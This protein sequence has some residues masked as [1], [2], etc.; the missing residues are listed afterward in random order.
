MAEGG[1]NGSFVTPHIGRGRGVLGVDEPKVGK[2][3]ML[4]Y[5]SATAS[6]PPYTK[7]NEPKSSTPANVGCDNVTQQLRDLIGELGSQIGDSIVT[8]LL[9]NQASILPDPAPSSE[10]LPSMTMPLSPNLDLSKL[11]LIVK[12]DI[13][14]PQMFRGDGSDKC[15]ILEWI[16]QM[17]VFL[18]KKG[19]NKADS[20]EEI[21]NHLCG[22]AKSIVKVKLKSSS[23]AVLCPEVV[24]EVLRRYFS[25]SP[26]SCQP[27]ADFYATQPKHN[28]CPVDYWVRLNEAAELA[29]AHLKRCGGKM[30]NMSSEIVMM[31]IRNCPNSDLASVFRCKPI[32]KW[33]AEEVQEAIDEHERDFRSRRQLPSAFKAAVNQAA[34][35]KGPV[36][37]QVTVESEDVGVNSAAC[38]ASPHPKTNESVE[39]GTLERVLKMLERVL[40]RTT[41]PAPGPKPQPSQWYRASPCAVCGDRSHSTRSHCMREKRCLN[42]L[43]FGHQRKQCHRAAGQDM[44]QANDNQGN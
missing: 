20:V 34:V 38:A 9:T 21:L 29:D 8:R 14:D 5:D 33:S 7:I 41:L 32:S 18:S 30:E 16:E 13:K 12:A 2:P 23:A 10:Q 17:E 40:E 35:V 11:N 6:F 25:E 27:L 36:S 4:V 31:F 15:T 26:G 28:E 39:S 37:T 42:C 43:E 19:C 22:R 44:A 24:Y 3:R 1:F